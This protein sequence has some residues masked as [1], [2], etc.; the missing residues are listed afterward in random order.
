MPQIYDV[1]IDQYRDVTQAEVEALVKVAQ[2]YGELRVSVFKLIN[3]LKVVLE[4]LEEAVPIQ[5]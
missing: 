1:A 2:R 5:Q 4:H 3:S